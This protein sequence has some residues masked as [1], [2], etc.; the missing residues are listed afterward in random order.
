MDA[1]PHTSDP[2]PGL[3]GRG[4]HLGLCSGQVGMGMAASL[5]LENDV[6]LWRGRCF[7]LTIRKLFLLILEKNLNSSTKDIHTCWAALMPSFVSFVSSPLELY[8]RLGLLPLGLNASE[9]KHRAA[10]P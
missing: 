5:H 1:G 9:R 8:K 3:P 4:I 10:R 7:M 6:Y 2:K